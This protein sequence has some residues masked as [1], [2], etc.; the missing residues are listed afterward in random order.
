LKIF[1]IEND[2]LIR[3]HVIARYLKN[4]TEEE[5]YDNIMKMLKIVKRQ[6]RLN[7]VLNIDQLCPKNIVVDALK[8][9]YHCFLYSEHSVNRYKNGIFTRIFK[10]SISAFNH[11]NKI[12][13]RLVYYS[14]HNNDPKFI[15]HYLE[16]RNVN[17]YLKEQEALDCY[18]PDT[19]I[20]NPA[21]SN[22]LNIRN[23][24]SIFNPRNRINEIINNNPNIIEDIHNDDNS[25]SSSSSSTVIE[26]IDNNDNELPIYPTSSDDDKDDDMDVH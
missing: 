21:F 25:L 12:F 15:T 11:Y 1:E 14:H 7:I 10:K 16:Y 2:V 5:Y 18:E 6:H 9:Y 20:D 4:L 3:E 17:K 23:D 22:E 24:L 13:G 8:N 26:D 19:I